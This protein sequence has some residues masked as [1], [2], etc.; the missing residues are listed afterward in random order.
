MYLPE[1]FLDKMREL[2]KDEFEL[3]LKSYDNIK[4]QGLRV[5][6]LKISVEDFKKISPFKLRPIPWCKDGFYFEE[7]ER[8]AKHPY[9]HAGLYYIQEPSAMTPAEV[10]NPQPG[11]RVLDLCA[12]PGGKSTQ[13]AAALDGQGVLVTNDINMNRVKAL[14]KNIELFGIKN[15]IV[16]NEKPEKIKKYFENYFDKI[17]VDAPCSGEG[18][19]RK[20][21]SMVK[22]WEKHDATYYMPIQKAIMDNVDYML[23][24]GGNVLYS[25]CTFSPEENEEIIK[26]FIKDNSQF[27]IVDI[28]KNNGFS[29]GRPEWV[30]GEKELEGCIRLWPHKLEGEGHF[31]SLMK[32]EVKENEKSFHF[33]GKSNVKPSKEFYDFVKENLN[34]SIK[35]EF[36]VH[37]NNL[38]LVPEGLPMLKGLKVLRSGWFLGTFKKN[39]FE[40]S[41]AMAM[42]LNY[43]DVKRV[44]NFNVGDKEVVKYLKGE[45]LNI[46]GEKGWTLVCVDGFSL[47]WAKQTGNMLKNLYPPAWRWLD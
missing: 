42:G 15:A 7:G 16:T 4:F 39:R 26:E 22:S 2:L 35:G 14:I 31:L 6:T 40:P 46:G 47:G 18:M 9:Y 32:K 34:T 30:N 11:N 17:L 12:A 36:E 33:E 37:N 28:P 8:P 19:F 43:K 23:R 29:K 41:H 44:I 21:P 13:I 27:Y 5:N 20:D 38:Y 45:T 1:K 25:T 3:F 24:A 10:L